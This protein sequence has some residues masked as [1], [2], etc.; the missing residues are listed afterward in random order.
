MKTRVTSKICMIKDLGVHGKLFGGNMLAWMDEAAAIYAR[1]FTG[2]DMVVTMRFGE[3]RFATPVKHEDIVEFYC[4]NPRPGTTSLSFEISAEVNSTTV[5]STDCT[6][7]H[8][9]ENGKKQKIDWDKS[10]LKKQD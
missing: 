5:F 9:D 2:T 6:F 3:I 10:A 8:L 4:S 1:Q 7:V